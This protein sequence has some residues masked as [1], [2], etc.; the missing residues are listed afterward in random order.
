[1]KNLYVCFLT[2]AAILLVGCSKLSV[3]PV[4]Q[5]ILGSLGS[6]FEI[7]GESFDIEDGK[8][9]ITLKRKKEGMPD[10]WEPDMTIGNGKGMCAPEFT[11]KALGSDGKVAATSKT[12]VTANQT[13]LQQ[14]LLTKVGETATITFEIDKDAKPVSFLL[15][16]EYTAIP[17]T[18]TDFNGEG[19]I[20][21]YPVHMTIHI[22]DS[23]NITGA[24]YYKRKGR[25]ALLYLKGKKDGDK[26]SMREYNR[27]GENTGNFEGT[28]TESDLYANFVCRNGKMK[29]HLQPTKL[30]PIDFSTV[31]FNQFFEDFYSVGD[32]YSD[33][34]DTG[35]SSWDDLLDEYEAYVNQYIKYY[36]KSQQGDMA[37]LEEAMSLLEEA[38][39]LAERIEAASGE[40]STAQAQRLVRIQQKMANAIR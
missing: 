1:M 6:Y 29:T 3:Q 27:H 37:A 20:S 9:A 8:L 28:I 2:L 26:F 18:L 15:S 11:L 36:K 38:R 32:T 4:S 16:S 31:D 13:E 7:E 22:D 30:T 5:E 25:T 21:S 12:N 40:L 17:K 33:Y 39:D 35:S 24:Y 34:S 10:P 23:G 14:L 19:T